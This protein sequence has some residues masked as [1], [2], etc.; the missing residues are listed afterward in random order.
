KGWRH[1]GW[2]LLRRSGFTGRCLKPR[3]ETMDWVET[4]DDCDNS[5]W[6]LTATYTDEVF[7]FRIKQRLENNCR[8]FYSASDDE[9]GGDMAGARWGTL[10]RAKRDLGACWRACL[11]TTEGE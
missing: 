3:R 10:K 11:E 7:T 6:S 2:H 1:S 4:F 9:L 8:W 5:V